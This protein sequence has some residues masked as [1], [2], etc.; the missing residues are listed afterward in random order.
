VHFTVTACAA[1][2]GCAILFGACSGDGTADV[3]PGERWVLLQW[4]ILFSGGVFAARS[5]CV[6]FGIT[7][8]RDVLEVVRHF[9]SITCYE[10][11]LFIRLFIVRGVPRAACLSAWARR[12]G[13]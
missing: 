10:I 7:V 2:V 8:N 11:S 5:A 3:F 6:S 1:A 4:A 13:L 9:G 12:R